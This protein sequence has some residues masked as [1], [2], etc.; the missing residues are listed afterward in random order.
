MAEEMPRRRTLKAT[1][2]VTYICSACGREFEKGWSDEEAESEF[3]EAFG[4]AVEGN[5]PIVCEDCY[6]KIMEWRDTICATEKMGYLCAR[7]KDHEMP[8]AGWTTGGMIAYWDDTPGAGPGVR[9]RSVDDY[10]LRAVVAEL[11]EEAS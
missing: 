6:V 8:H 2:T 11:S 5:E 3:A 1:A 4:R 7:Q 9:V 10:A